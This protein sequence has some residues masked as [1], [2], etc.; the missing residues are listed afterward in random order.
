MTAIP[1]LNGE[2]NYRNYHLVASIN[3]QKSCCCNVS[4]TLTTSTNSRERVRRV[5]DDEGA[6]GRNETD[7]N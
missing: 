2:K 3:F 6:Q 1:A 4:N 7:S 5:I